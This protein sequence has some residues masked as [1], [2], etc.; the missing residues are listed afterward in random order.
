MYCTSVYALG[1]ELG[2][3]KS[4]TPYWVSVLG[5]TNK[6]EGPTS[7]P[8]LVWTDEFGELRITAWLTLYKLNES[9]SCLKMNLIQLWKKQVGGPF[10]KSS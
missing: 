5:Y 6:G 9:C 7:K 3:L 8:L 2:G 4:Y 10:V 1:I